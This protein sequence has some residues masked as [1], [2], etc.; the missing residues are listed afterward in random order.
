M[1]DPERQAELIEAAVAYVGRGLPV[2]PCNGKTPLTE[3]GFRDASTDTSTVLAWWARWPEANIGIP[4]GDR[5]GVDVI[6][7]DTQHGGLATLRELEQKHGKLPA[8]VEVLTPSGGQ[9]LLVRAYP[10]DQVDRRQARLRHRHP[11]RRRLRRRPAVRRRERPPLQAAPRRGP[12]GAT[13]LDRR[14][15]RGER[16]DTVHDG[17]ECDSGRTAA[18]GDA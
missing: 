18:G 7:V 4:T 5:S 10:A 16:C 8:T 12:G 3:H 2:F 1:T 13:Q 11:R 6:D 15:P 14:P 9:A 17:G